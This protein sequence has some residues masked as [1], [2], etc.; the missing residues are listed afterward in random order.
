M[1][2]YYYLVPDS[3]EN[4]QS[5]FNFIKEATFR[6]LGNLQQAITVQQTYTANL[7]TYINNILS[8]ITKLEDTIHKFEQKPTMEQDTT[9]IN[10][11]DFDPD[12]D[13]PNI[14]R[15]HNNTAIVSVQEWLTSPEPELS[16]ATN[17]Q[18]ETTDRDPPNNTYN[19]LEESHGYENFPKHIQNHTTEQHQITSGHNIDSEEIPHLE[20]DWNDSQF[21]DVDTN[22]INRHNMHSESERI[23]KDYTQHLLDLSENQYY[24]KENPINQ[25]QYFSP[26]PDYYGTPSRRSQT[27]P[28]KLLVTILH[29]QTQQTFSAGTHM[30]EENMF[31]SMNIDFLVKRPDQLKAGKPERDDK[32]ISSE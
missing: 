21:A 22:L 1:E 9:Q 23:R 29:P 27:Q 16:D 13:G 15:A 11:Q 7:C 20:E 25:L 8:R 28:R 30:E 12:I 26:D 14:P 17:F 10:A 6:N 32:T 18:E 31:F 19:N 3:L 4:L 2:K 24:Y 5:H